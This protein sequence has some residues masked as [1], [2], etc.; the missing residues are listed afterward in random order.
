MSR[1]LLVFLVGALTA[2]IAGCGEDSVTAVTPTSSARGTLLHDPPL[3]IASL[4]ATT[5]TASLNASASGAQ[6]L[7]IAGAPTCGVDF[8][9]IQYNTVGGQNEATTASGALM[10][11]TGSA[12]QGS[13]PRPNVL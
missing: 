2:A 13:G 6:L 12:A 3:R 8:S 7:E 9:Y 11:P 10:V 5:F 1:S 4:T